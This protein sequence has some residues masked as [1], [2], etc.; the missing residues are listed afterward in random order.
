MSL[1]FSTLD[2][3]AR[4][5][6]VLSRERAAIDEGFDRITTA[7][8]PDAAHDAAFELGESLDGVETLG[9]LLELADATL[10]EAWTSLVTGDE[11]RARVEHWLQRIRSTPS[12]WR[13]LAKVY[14]HSFG[15][16]DARRVFELVA[17]RTDRES[18][19]RLQGV[20]AEGGLRATLDAPHEAR[21]D[22][23]SLHALVLVR[24]LSLA[25]A[26]WEAL[27]AMTDR[28][29]LLA[30]LDDAPRGAAPSLLA[31]HAPLA[32]NTEAAWSSRLAADV[33][34]RLDATADDDARP[35]QG[36]EAF[37]AR[38]SQW[39]FGRE[40]ELFEVRRDARAR[41]DWR[42]ISVEG[43][44]GSGKS[45]FVR[46][47]LAPAIAW[48]LLDERETVW[49]VAV[50]RPLADPIASLARALASDAEVKA[51]EAALSGDDDHALR[52]W[53][54]D[55]DAATHT[56]LV[57]D[58]L[59]ELL[60]LSSMGS[61]KVARFDRL[62]AAALGGDAR[63]RLVSA[64]R[65]D[66][67]AVFERLPRLGERLP[68]ATRVTLGTPDREA[69]RAAIV[70]PAS[71]VGARMEPGLVDRMLDDARDAT[72]PLATLQHAL[73]L[74]WEREK[75]EARGGRLLR[76]ETYTSFGGVAGALAKAGDALFEALGPEAQ[77]HARSL[78]LRMV[79][80]GR[81]SSDSRRPLAVSAVE[82]GGE[83]TRGAF[84][85]LT[86]S[87]LVVVRDGQAELVHETLLTR[88][89]ALRGWIDA[90]RDALEVRDEVED[91]TTSWVSA[92]R[93]AGALPTGALLTRFRR[94]P[95]ALLSAEAQAYVARARRAERR[96]R[97]ATALVVAVV[98]AAGVALAA[99]L[100]SMGAAQRERDRAAHDR[101]ESERLRAETY[102]ERVLEQAR[103]A[104]TLAHSV[105][106]VG[107]SLELAIDAA[108]RLSERD[109][110]QGV[111]EIA[112]RAATLAMEW[113]VYGHD[114]AGLSR[115]DVYDL[116]PIAT[117]QSIT[118]L[119]TGGVF[120]ASPESQ[121][122]GQDQFVEM[123]DGALDPRGRYALFSRMESLLTQNVL[124]PLLVLTSLAEGGDA[125]ATLPG[126]WEQITPLPDGAFT[127]HLHTRPFAND[128]MWHRIEAV[129]DGQGVRLV[130]RRLGR[131]PMAPVLSLAR[132]L[133]A[134][135]L[136]STQPREIED[137][138]T[139]RPIALPP[140]VRE[141]RGAALSS[142]G[143]WLI[144]WGAQSAHR[145][146]V[147]GASLPVRLD[148][149]PVTSVAFRGDD[150]SALIAD[151]QGGLRVW[152]PA[153]AVPLSNRVR[154]HR[155]GAHVVRD[156]PEL[157]AYW[158]VGA[159]P[160][161]RAW[162]RDLT[163]RH[164]QWVPPDPSGRR[165]VTSEIKATSAALFL[166]D[167][168][169][170]RTINAALDALVLRTTEFE[171]RTPSELHRADLLRLACHLLRFERAY[172]AVRA[173]CDPLLPPVA[174]WVTRLA[175]Q[176]P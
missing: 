17:A 124:R 56:L 156:H 129:V 137:A 126:E 31:H 44:S 102:R 82:G 96:A 2:K 120:R 6:V 151:E 39:Y 112:L 84:E 9:T 72:A 18:A 49:R 174:P 62:L 121:R 158:S 42:W 53:L 127:A 123:G 68:K 60:T 163:P 65:L 106:D 26:Q 12:L 97:L 51:L 143:D 114:E 52:T 75:P 125:V 4:D 81:G 135:R 20:L 5:I 33:K 155:E 38:T 141:L 176:E 50:M 167:A 57:V 74:L 133:S 30:T 27:S 146:A 115:R 23:R 37:E 95:D 28:P 169:P 161:L 159:E 142:S 77:T 16:P 149:P 144:A 103:R 89:K 83:A 94:A 45:S 119:T 104:M 7:P 64:L 46:A 148:T 71:R 116:V 162:N 111:T 160:F 87:R 90:S 131:D 110:P 105:E 59:E 35:Y 67:A 166:P 63:L 88:W 10:E 41:G 157:D 8:T 108:S 32:L 134:T 66:F 79:R 43:L 132:G 101:S 98:V 154:A 128:P 3:A 61:T 69:L 150:Q 70:G 24:G 54:L 107:G 152:S 153:R 140:G 11:T 19:L 118:C 170:D 85:A 136:D 29:T 1:D 36:L 100:R 173:V 73:T 40:P 113:T 78:L 93:P 76:H 147:R 109:D 86:R 48:G 99:A 138:S 55:R 117:S 139:H 22:R 25:P 58:Q 92:G 145:I 91:A 130:S 80:V 13:A 171:A 175:S 165:G 15:D 168:S 34:A 47:A 14:P 172:V 164:V 21:R 122:V